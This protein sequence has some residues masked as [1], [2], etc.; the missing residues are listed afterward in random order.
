MMTAGDAAL[1]AEITDLVFKEISDRIA[2]GNAKLPI[3]LGKEHHVG[4]EVIRFIL[5]CGDDPLS[6]HGWKPKRQQLIVSSWMGRSQCALL[7][8]GLE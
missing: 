4:C 3:S 6:S 2:I 1:R 8:T 7:R 5:T